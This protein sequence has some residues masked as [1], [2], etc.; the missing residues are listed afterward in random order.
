M[1]SEK[2]I[3]DVV[4]EGVREHYTRA[5]HHADSPAHEV[6]ESRRRVRSALERHAVGRDNAMPG[7]ALADL[8]PLRETTVRDIVAELRDDPE[9]PPIGNCADGYYVI[10]TTAELEDYVAGMKDTI[11]TKRERLQANVKA[12]NRRQQYE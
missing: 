4:A 5:E 11:A 7:S 2:P 3:A 10:A 8:V 12:F 1:S 9:G 6:R